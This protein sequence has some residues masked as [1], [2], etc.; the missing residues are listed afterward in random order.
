MVPKLIVCSGGMI[1]TPE[2]VYEHF[3]ISLQLSINEQMVLN[4][5]VF[6]KQCRQR[7]T[8]GSLLPVGAHG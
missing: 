1:Y 3:C 5:S 8:G 6:S 4:D 2:V 7:E